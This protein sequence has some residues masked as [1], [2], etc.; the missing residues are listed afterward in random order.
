[1]LTAKDL[2]VAQA[3]MTGESMPVEK[4]AVQ[5]DAEASNPLELGNI[6]FMSTNVVSGS[7]TPVVLA[8]GNHTH[9]GALAGRVTAA[10]HIPT[11]FQAGVNQLNWLLLRFMLV[12]AALPFI[13][14][15]HRFEAR[16]THPLTQRRWPSTTDR[17]A[18]GRVFQLTGRPMAPN[19][20]G[21]GPPLA[22]R[23][24]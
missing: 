15:S 16:D 24:A 3:V 13:I 6:L 18:W 23:P 22:A 17:L 21:K 10:D 14:A 2:L 5:R 9:F 12:M 19:V 8:T 11:Q 1:M 4:F 20:E 7:A